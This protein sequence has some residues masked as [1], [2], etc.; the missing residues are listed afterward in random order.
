MIRRYFT[1]ERFSSG[2]RGAGWPSHRSERKPAGQRAVGEQPDAVA[3]A[4]RRAISPDGRRSSTE[5]CTWWETTRTPAS[6]RWPRRARR[7]SWSARRDAPCRRDGGH[8]ATCRPRRTPGIVVVPPVQL[9]EVER[10]H[11]QALHAID[12][13]WPRSSCRVRCGSAI[14]DRARTWCAPGT[15]PPP[16]RRRPRRSA[17]ARY[18]P[19]SAS[20]PV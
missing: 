11:A 10:V 2:S 6:R 19:I 17:R 18:V 14:A 5:Y 1:S 16:R 4:E 12:R 13:P 7:R 15:R 8:R 20:T 3:G 9:H